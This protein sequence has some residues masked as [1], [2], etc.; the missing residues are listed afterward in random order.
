MRGENGGKNRM[1]GRW[2]I[3]RSEG[4]HREESEVWVW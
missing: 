1:R 3:E 2:E 4:D